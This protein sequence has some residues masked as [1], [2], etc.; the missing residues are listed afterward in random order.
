MNSIPNKFLLALSAACLLGALPASAALVVYSPGDL[1]MSFRSTGPGQGAGTTY[2]VNVGQA[3]GFRDETAV[4]TL[5]LG[6]IGTDL[7]AIF[8]DNWSSRT[9]ILWGVAGTPSNT[10]TVGGD[11]APTLYASK[12][13][14]TPGVPGTQ[15]GIAGS[16]TRLA[17][18]TTMVTALDTFKTYQATANSPRAVIQQDS[19]ANDWREFLAS[20]GNSAYTAGNKDFGGFSEI[21][22]SLDQQLSLFRVIGSGNGSYEGS[23]SIN[24]SGNITFVP[25][26]SSALL[27][28]LGTGLLAFRRRRA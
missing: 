1:V 3:S 9:D 25:E 26:P 20:N 8:G 18:A 6:N 16:S 13:Q 23:F 14:T 21:E 27:G 2:L 11:D 5:S 24:S 19:D 15:A 10:G 17:I 28:V 4:G 12:A 22:G 7:K